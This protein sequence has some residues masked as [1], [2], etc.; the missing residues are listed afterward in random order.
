[1]ILNPINT[2]YLTH[3]YNFPYNFPLFLWGSGRLG[4]VCQV[5]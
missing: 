1:L 4:I 5:F 3:P 2:R